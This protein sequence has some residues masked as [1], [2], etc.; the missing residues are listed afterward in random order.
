MNM[1]H[2]CQETIFFYKI[3][4]YLLCQSFYWSSMN[5]RWEV[6]V[7]QLAQ[8]GQI[9]KFAGFFA[10]SLAYSKEHAYPCNLNQNNVIQNCPQLV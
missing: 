8:K 3:S 4:Q 6:S 5:N 9:N 2:S 10:G 1:T 7:I